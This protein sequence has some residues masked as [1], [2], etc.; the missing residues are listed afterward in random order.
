MTLRRSHNMSAF[1]VAG[2]GGAAQH[3]LQRRT[4]ARLPTMGIA[5]IASPLN[6]SV[7]RIDVSLPFRLMKRWKLINVLDPCLAWQGITQKENNMSAASDLIERMERETGRRINFNDFD[8]AAMAGLFG[9]V[10]RMMGKSSHDKRDDI[11]AGLLIVHQ[12]TPEYRNEQESREMIAS[13]LSS[14]LSPDDIRAMGGGV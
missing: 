5:R 7:R 12:M 4:L 9:A 11:V 10:A 14:G 2:G 1:Y 13:L 8:N 3:P 6:L